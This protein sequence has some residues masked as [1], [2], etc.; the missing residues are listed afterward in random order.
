MAESGLLAT[1]FGKRNGSVSRWYISTIQLIWPFYSPT[2]AITSNTVTM[3]VQKASCSSSYF[4]PSLSSSFSS[5]FYSSL[6]ALGPFVSVASLFAS[7]FVASLSPSR[8]FALKH[9]LYHLSVTRFL[10]LSV[11]LPLRGQ[12]YYQSPAEIFFSP[13]C[14][15]STSENSNL[16]YEGDD[17]LLRMW[18]FFGWNT[19]GNRRD[20][21]NLSEARSS[22]LFCW[23]EWFCSF[24]N[25]PL[26]RDFTPWSGSFLFRI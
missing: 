5:S 1:P 13:R 25:I 19:P 12:L 9:I 24:V 15:Y 17:E 18:G 16:W 26:F 23:G 14:L 8:L 22:T 21:V 20:K 3:A 11:F 4:P 6:S 7:L 2:K 10:A